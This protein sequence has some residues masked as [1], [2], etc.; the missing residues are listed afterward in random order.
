MKFTGKIILSD[1]DFT[2]TDSNRRLVERNLKAVEAFK[3]EG[4][5]FALA[6]GRDSSVM[7]QLRPL[8]AGLCNAP[9][10]HCNGAY[11]YDHRA[12]RRLGEVTLKHDRVREVY[13]YASARFPGIGIR[14]SSDIG[15]LVLRMNSY[16]EGEI[17]YADTPDSYIRCD[18]PGTLERFESHAWYRL[19]FRADPAQLK[20]VRE[21]VES[22]FGGEFAFSLAEPTIYEFQAKNATKGTAIARLRRVL[23]EQEIAD[24]DKLTVYAAGDF[25]NDLEM[26]KACD[27]PACPENAIDSVKS[28]AKIHLCRCDDGAIGDLIERISGGEQ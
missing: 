8:V 20:E 1:I 25:E 2:F 7:G 16:M 27:I 10:I 24:S 6:T 14:I 28:V 17:R 11:L 18:E 22:K 26:L 15:A 21:A 9:C 5:L 4:G 19:A 13:R 12:G 23:G 3:A